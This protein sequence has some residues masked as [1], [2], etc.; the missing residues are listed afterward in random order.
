VGIILWHKIFLF[1]GNKSDNY[2]LKGHTRKALEKL[3]HVVTLVSIVGAHKNAHCTRED[4]ILSAQ[5]ELLVHRPGP[6]A[7]SRKPTRDRVQR[8]HTRARAR[9]RPSLWRQPIVI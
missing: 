5:P 9:A 3:H 8:P 1:S 6:S 2:S 4:R 7:S